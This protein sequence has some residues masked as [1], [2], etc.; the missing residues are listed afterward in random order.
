MPRGKLDGKSKLVDRFGGQVDQLAV[1]R[2]KWRGWEKVEKPKA[3]ALD[4]GWSEGVPDKTHHLP[5]SFTY[6]QPPF[7]LASRVGLKKKENPGHPQEL[8]ASWGRVKKPNDYISINRV[9]QGREK[10]ILLQ[11]NLTFV[12]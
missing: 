4:W 2:A 8:A 7:T 11:E 6:S 12:S 10:L 5:G 3:A 1:C 9:F